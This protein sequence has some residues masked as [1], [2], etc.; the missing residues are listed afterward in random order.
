[1]SRKMSKKAKV[2]KPKQNSQNI[3]EA[4][5]GPAPRIPPPRSL[6]RVDREVRR[7]NQNGA[8]A[9]QAFTLA[10]GHDQ[11]LVVT[12]VSG[13]AV[14]YVDCWRIK[15]ITVWA[16]SSN[17]TSTTATIIPN[18]VSSD[19]MRN[20]P[21]K[22]FSCSSRSSAEPACFKILTSK[23]EPL[24]SWHDTSNV[25]VASTLFTMNVAVGGGATLSRVTMDIEFETLVNLVGFPLGYGV[26][27]S[28]TTLG[29]VG[30]RSILTNMSL[31]GI[32]NLG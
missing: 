21:Q 17:D 18:G 13:A 29:T 7:F 16:L 15:S 25:G 24:G 1:M 23:S 5:L 26:V 22:I 31:Q 2:G 4:R 27:T 12:N 10:N 8:V 28:T 3:M 6:T 14:P 20:D 9:N 30:A 19:N 11:F 32:N